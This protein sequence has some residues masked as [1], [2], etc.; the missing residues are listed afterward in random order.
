MTIGGL[1]YS[2]KSLWFDPN[3]CEVSAGGY[4]DNKGR[5]VFVVFAIPDDSLMTIKINIQILS[6][7]LF[8]HQGAFPY[9]VKSTVKNTVKPCGTSFDDYKAV[10]VE[11]GLYVIF[12]YF[13]GQT[14]AEEA[15]ASAG[16]T[17]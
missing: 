8:W 4:S 7:I 10:V 14:K 17:R 3:V 1:E 9:I 15:K 2:A 6:Q 11:D 16:G 12:D 13:G 5:A